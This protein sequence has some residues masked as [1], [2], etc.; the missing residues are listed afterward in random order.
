M[1]KLVKKREV[2]DA[3]CGQLQCY[4]SECDDCE[5]NSSLRH[6]EVAIDNLKVEISEIE[7]DVDTWAY[8]IMGNKEAETTWDHYMSLLQSQITVEEYEKLYP[9][10]FLGD[11]RFPDIFAKELIDRCYNKLVGLASKRKSR[12]AY[13]V[14]GVFLMKF[15]GRMTQD[16]RRL[17][18]KN[19]KWEHEKD[20]LINEQ[21]KIERE[22]YLCDFR[23]KVK[24]YKEGIKAKIPWGS[25]SSN[26]RKSIDYLLKL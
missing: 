25:F 10:H 6:I 1:T 19:S 14:L 17:I 26:E 13:Q 15:G 9:E 2:L 23:E 22:K 18:L 21:D 7:M 12:L 24:N 20:Q 3:R 5:T 16:V 8:T 11:F 4:K